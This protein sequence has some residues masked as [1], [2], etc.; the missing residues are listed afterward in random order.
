MQVSDHI[1]HS[2]RDEG[3]KQGIDL[4]PVWVDEDARVWERNN[5][6]QNQTPTVTKRDNFKVGVDGVGYAT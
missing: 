2:N 1:S 6:G 3:L 4:N 5:G